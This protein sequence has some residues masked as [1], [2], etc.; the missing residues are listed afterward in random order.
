MDAFLSGI[1]SE[2]CRMRRGEAR[3][4]QVGAERPHRLVVRGAQVPGPYPT[5]LHD[6]LLVP[7]WKE[8]TDTLVSYDDDWKLDF[9]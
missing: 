2:I 7:H 3:S 6:D 8:F 4:I 1:K 5:V 9:S